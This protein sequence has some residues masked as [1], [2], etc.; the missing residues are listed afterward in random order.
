MKYLLD[1][2]VISDFVKGDKN[3]V[4][5]LKNTQPNEIAVS[6]IT[7]MEIRY[8]LAL[9]PKRAEKIKSMILDLLAS[10]TVLDFNQND[11]LESAKIRALLKQRGQPIGCY[12]ILLAGTAINNKLIFVSSNVSEFSRINGLIL[13]NWR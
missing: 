4:S 10:I 1:T 13:E 6:S 11:A 7:V 3:T 2:C 12:D 9:N 5:T 8:G